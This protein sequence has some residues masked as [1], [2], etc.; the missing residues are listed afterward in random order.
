MSPSLASPTAFASRYIVVFHG[1]GER[2]V[3]LMSRIL[4]V[5][6]ARGVRVRSG[7]TVLRAR[8]PQ[9][10]RPRVYARLGVA[11]ADLDDD[12]LRLLRR[13]ELVAAVVA[14][15]PC[16]APASTAAAP[17]AEV[18]PV[19]GQSW[20]LEVM[21]VSAGR[22][23]TGRGVTVA[24]LDTGV[25]LDHPDLAGRFEEDS[26]AV[27]F[28]PN[29]RVQDRHGHGT[30]CAGVVGGP[31]RSHSGIH[32]GV[33][34]GARL[35]VGKV[36]S[37]TGAGFADSIL[38]GI[39]WAAENGARVIS[40]SCVSSRAAGE[41]HAVAYQRVAESLLQASPGVLLLAAAGNSS[42]RPWY[43]RAVGN[44]AACPSLMAVAAVRR[45]RNVASFSGRQMD[46]IGMVN[47]SAPGVGVHSAWTGASYRT[48]SGT[49]MAVSHV[50]GL[51]ALYLEEQPELSAREL[52]RALEA[53]AEPL[54]DVRD[55]GSGLVQAGAAL[56][57]ALDTAA[58]PP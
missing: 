50:A 25:D 32:Y 12:Q 49:S 17:E 3:S 58:S 5:G 28:V 24:V 40:L 57:P 21:G 16:L 27:C 46:E 35:L 7:T 42:E 51:A 15:E 14:N 33:A 34:P 53:R 26:S 6:E 13:Q 8:S 31:A 23:P 45:A 22:R 54:G 1:P 9:A 55:F 37:D 44:P 41:P 48:M 56:E 47:V 18:T 4:G 19:P 36:L 39:D 38:D 10:P 11:V 2:C 20:C 29:E 43:T 52:W 30:H